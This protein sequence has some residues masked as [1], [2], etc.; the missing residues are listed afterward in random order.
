MTKTTKSL[1]ASQ[2]KPEWILIDADGVVLGRLAAYV[3]TVLRGKTKPTYTP[4]MDCGDHVI[5]I[6]A[7][8]IALTGNKAENE[9]F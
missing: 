8:K 1:C 9:K 5:I 2:L 4:N 6:N 7:D 3:A